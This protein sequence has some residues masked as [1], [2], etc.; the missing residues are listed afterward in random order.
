MKF[1]TISVL[2]SVITIIRMQMHIR[3][4]TIT[5]DKKTLVNW[6]TVT[7]IRIQIQIGRMNK[8]IHDSL[9]FCSQG[10]NYPYYSCILPHTSWI[11]HMS[12]NI[13]GNR[14]SI[15]DEP[16]QHFAYEVQRSSEINP[17][18]A[19][20]R[21]TRELS[22]MSVAVLHKTARPNSSFE[23]GQKTD[24]FNTPNFVGARNLTR[25]KRQFLGRESLCEVR[26]QFIAPQS[27]L[28]TRGQTT[29]NWKKYRANNNTLYNCRKLDVRD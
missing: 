24:D 10:S 23:R 17:A 1:P 18:Q 9:L 14:S 7:S 4:Y 26:T 28:N 29:M 21:P 15:S 16:G 11:N 27:A 13:I 22:M 20:K 8:I 3:V 12:I 2:I 5:S 6:M 19:S 25:T